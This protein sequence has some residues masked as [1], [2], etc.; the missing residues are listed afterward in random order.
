MPVRQKAFEAIKV[1]LAMVLVMTHPDFNEPFILYTDAL[2][3]SV[4]AI[5]HQLKG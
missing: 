1:K 4:G 3:E 2:S 5:L